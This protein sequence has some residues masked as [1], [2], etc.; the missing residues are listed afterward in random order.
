[1]PNKPKQLDVQMLVSTKWSCL[2]R[3]VALVVLDW[4]GAAGADVALKLSVKENCVLQYEELAAEVKITN[5]SGVPLIVDER[6]HTTVWFR[7][8]RSRDVLAE[9]L[10]KQ[11]PLGSFVLTPGE[12]REFSLDLSLWYDLG[13][14]DRYLIAMIL[15]W[16]GR[17]FVSNEVVVDVVPGI[18]LVRVSK[19]AP[20]SLDQIR[21]YSL[22]Y[23][24]RQGRERLFLRVD[25]EPSH[26]NYGVFC[27]GELVRFR[28]PSLSVD[29]E[30]NIEVIHQNAPRSFVRTV[31]SSEPDRVRL[32][33]QHQ[34]ELAEKA[35]EPTPQR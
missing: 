5:L 23:W 24:T 4:S 20:G 33:E 17:T 11:P 12:S 19:P 16:E 29:S 8:R 31:F 2:A 10:K 30:G 26:L 34:E 35:K 25:E 15:D 18:E 1:M 9:R 13:T 22:R 28:K 21:H 32:K 27:L 6:L 14:P 3:V 7:V